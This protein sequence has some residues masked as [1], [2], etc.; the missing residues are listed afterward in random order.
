MA[1]IHLAYNSAC[2][3]TFIT[4]CILTK[5]TNKIVPFFPSSFLLAL[6]FDWEDRIIGIK[7][8]N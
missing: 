2:K 7:L 8:A 3:Q 4:K 5:G 6:E 1:K